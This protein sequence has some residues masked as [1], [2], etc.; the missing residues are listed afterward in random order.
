[1]YCTMCMRLRRRAVSVSVFVFNCALYEIVVARVF[2][3][4]DPIPSLYLPSGG[5]NSHTNQTE[6]KK[7]NW[8]TRSMTVKHSASC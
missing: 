5:Q 2:D 3:V 1:M 8:C 4:I 6:V 7:R